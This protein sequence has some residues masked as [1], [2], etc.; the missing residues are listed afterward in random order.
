MLTDKAIRALKPQDKPYKAS[1]GAGL[2]LLVQSTG[3]R[4]WRLKYRFAGKEKL[5]AL[6]VYPEVS[7][8]DAR[9][10]RD[11][12]WASPDFPDTS[13]RVLQPVVTGHA[14]NPPRLPNEIT[15]N[16]PLAVGIQ[17]HYN[18]FERLSF[19][20]VAGVELQHHIITIRST[21]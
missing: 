1:D 11:E 5:A 21:G 13:L 10:R 7:L 2:Y 18:R 8:A 4:L 12:L 3:A 16:A 20:V 9:S 15:P 14:V 6:G 19:V 17:R